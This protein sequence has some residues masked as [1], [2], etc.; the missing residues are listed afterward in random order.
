MKRLAIVLL[1]ST[2]L[3]TACEE[4]D[5]VVWSPDG[6]HLAVIASDGLRMGDHSGKISAPL[7]PNARLVSWLPD[8]VHALIVTTKTSSSWPE[9]KKTLTASECREVRVAAEK[10]WK[11]GLRQHETVSQSFLESHGFVYLLQKNG[12][13]K[14]IDRLSKRFPSLH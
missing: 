6:K 14:T 7:I 11:S 3:L 5:R 13:Q 9:I 1:L 4:M 10:L 2:M 12:R 8:S